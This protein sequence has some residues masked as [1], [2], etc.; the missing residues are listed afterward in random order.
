MRRTYDAVVVLRFLYAIFVAVLLATL[1]GVGIAAFYSGPKAPEYPS[2]LSTPAKV[3]PAPNPAG[4]EFTKEQ[5]EYEAKH[6]KYRALSETY[7][8]N[9]SVIALIAAIIILAASLTL[10]QR[11]LVI[12]DGFL[13]GGLFVLLYSIGRGF[14]SG[15]DVFRFIVVA[16]GFAIAVFLGYLK[17][18]KPHER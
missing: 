7:N 13:L 10:F 15:D 6:R 3:I 17:F 2:R 5:R 11:I 14:G 16:V 12:A 8:R 9:V 4:E 1:V 18:A